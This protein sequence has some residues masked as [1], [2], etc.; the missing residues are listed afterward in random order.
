MR[1]HSILFDV[2]QLL[3]LR[4][5]S[6]VSFSMDNSLDDSYISWTSSVLVHPGAIISILQL[7]PSIKCDDSK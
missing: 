7:I 2:F 1:S 3:I 4:S 6:D 5:A